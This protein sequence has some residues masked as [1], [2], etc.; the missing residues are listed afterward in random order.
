M[1]NG[2]LKPGYNIQAAVEGEY[3]LG[4]DVSSERSDV[5]TL[6]PFLE[7]LNGLELF[8]LRNIIC[9]AGYKSEENYLYLKSHNLTSCIKPVNYEQQKKKNY[10]TK[11]GRFENMEYHELGDVFVC[12]A[13]RI[14]WRIGTKHEKTKGEK[15]LSLSHRFKELREESLKIITNDFGRQLRMNRSI[16]SEGAFGVLKQD[17]GFRRFL[18]RGKTN[19]KTEF[20]LLALSYNIKKLLLRFLK[21]AAKYDFLSP[22]RRRILNK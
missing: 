6:I 11:Y 4:I 16:Q 2:Q 12:H 9:D 7:K 21:T 5:N 1:K 14:L 22:K 8:V 18:C 17:H 3:I 10:R 19:I 15:T 13:G 20:L